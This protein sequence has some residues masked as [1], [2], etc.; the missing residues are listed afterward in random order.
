MISFH[1]CLHA[2]PFAI[3]TSY[4][5]IPFYACT[6][7]AWNAGNYIVYTKTSGHS[8]I[9][10]LLFLSSFMS[11]IVC[12]LLNG[13]YLINYYLTITISQFSQCYYQSGKLLATA[14]GSTSRYWESQLS[15]VVMLDSLNLKNVFHVIG[16]TLGNSI[17]GRTELAQDV[18][19]FLLGDF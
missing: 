1:S 8:L 17:K 2:F 3:S 16:N 18:T 14:V 11:G 7:L 15:C 12:K 19:I 9:Y 4:I 10:C 13:R 5:L 6:L